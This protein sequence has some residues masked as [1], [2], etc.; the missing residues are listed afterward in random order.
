MTT[1]R[2]KLSIAVAVAVAETRDGGVPWTGD[3]RGEDLPSVAVA[4]AV[5]ENAVEW[6]VKSRRAAI[7]NGVM[8]GGDYNYTCYTI[9]HNYNAV[10]YS[11]V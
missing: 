4:V 5:A 9:T 8:G 1:R 6:R 11:T 10:Q 7:S 3:W 2:R